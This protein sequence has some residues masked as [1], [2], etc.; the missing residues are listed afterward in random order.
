MAWSLLIRGGTVID[1]TGPPRREL[2]VAVEGERSPPS[3][4]I[5]PCQA[6][7]VI[8]AGG[9]VVAPGFIDAHSHSDLFYIGCPSSESKIRQGVHHRGRRDVL[10]LPGADRA[11]PRGVRAGLGGRHRRERRPPLGDVRAVPRR[12]ALRAAV[13]QRRPL[14]RPRRA[15]ARRRSG[16][17]TGRSRRGSCGPCSGCSTR[18][19]TRAPTATRPGSSTRRAPTR[20]PRSW[21]RSP[22][23]CAA[24]EGLYFSH[25]RGESAM[26]EAPSARP[27]ASGRRAASACRSPTSR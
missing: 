4:R 15:P 24:R 17:T 26:V 9:H 25:V 11:G 10:V 7:R 1:G 20:R 12:A 6:D 13:D 3:A 8:D 23:A 16:P 27:S 22:G 18:R 14:R 2:D 5:C 19:W 21:S